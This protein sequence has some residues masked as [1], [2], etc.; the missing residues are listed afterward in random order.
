MNSNMKLSCAIAAILGGTT[1]GTAQAAAATGT[2][3]ADTSSDTIQEITVTA[4]RRTENIQDVPITIQ[5]L[6]GETLSQLNVQTFDEF[7]KYLPNVTQGSY[8]PGQSNIYMRGLGQGALGVQGEGSVGIFPNVAV[9][10]DEQSAQLP[11]RNLDVYAADMERIEVLE[12]P[13][14]TVFGAGAEAGVV[15]YITNK[16]KIDVTEGSVD[17]DYGTTAHGGNNSSVVAVINLPLIE[18]ALA[19]RGV[20]YDDNRG[21]YIDNVP[22]TFSRSGYDLGLALYNG[23]KTNFYGKVT[24]PGVVPAN[25]ETIN[26]YSQTGNGIN[27]VTYQGIRVGLEW[28]V[29]DHWDALLQQSYQDMNSQGVFYD[30]PSTGGGQYGPTSAG[31]NPSAGLTGGTALAP[32]QVSLFNPSY[33]KDKFENTALTINGNINDYKIVYAGSY[34]VRNVSQQTDYTNYARGKWGYYYQCTGFSKSYDAPTKCYSPSSVWTDTEKLTHLSQELRLSTPDEYRFR[35]LT[36]LFYEDY[37]IDDDTEWLYRTV[38]T[39]SAALTTEC[40]LNIVPPPGQTANDP[41]VRNS[42]TGF[43]DDVQRGFTQKA[44]FTSADFDI[45]PKV[46]TLTGGTR[47]FHFDDHIAGGDVGSFYCK[48]YGGY[49]TTNFSPCSTTNNNGFNHDFYGGPTGSIVGYHP[50]PYGY[51]FNTSVVNHTTESGF[52]SRGNLSWKITQDVMVYYTYSQGYRPGGFNRGSNGALPQGYV[53]GVSPS[54]KCGYTGKPACQY[55]TPLTWGSDSLTNQ[56]IGWK[57]EWFNHRL[58]VNGAV[59]QEKWN[60]VQ[61]SF[62]DPQQGLGNLTFNTNGPDYKVRG[63]ELQLVGQPMLGLTITSSMA[64]N[65]SQLVNSPS[66]TNNNPSSQSAG[67]GGPYTGPNTTSLGQSITSIPNVYGAPGSRLAM[68]PPFEGNIRARYEW[69][70]GDYRAFLQAGASRIG[71][72]LSQTGNVTP[73]VMPGYTTYDASAGVSKDRWTVSAYGQNLGDNQAS[74]YTSSNQFVVTQTVL[75]PRVLGLRFGY[76]FGEGK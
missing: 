65:S 56:E 29:N 33:N 43:F 21:G 63:V 5:A 54:S 18:N 27:P 46:L 75:R 17:A 20:V 59:Y 70:M 7:I 31:F 12:G 13:Q 60:N 19:I 72:T 9:Y 4:Q 53:P 41:N 25:S 66:L 47:Y 73:F 45:I 55:Y 26:N 57:T 28:K 64:W 39:C 51:N 49:T 68:S 23:G 32:L 71:E 2:D 34:L 52:R 14:G 24:S 38:P 76:K 37:K 67:S 61:T 58:Q 8:G 36:G 50:G 30:M 74:T 35:L 15:R 3:T 10:L 69:P 11:S 1:G 48:L 40:Y 6:T 42:Q 16:P 22:S 62:F 44:I